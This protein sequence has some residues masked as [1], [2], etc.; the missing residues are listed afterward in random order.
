[1]KRTILILS[2]VLL[3]TQGC[4]EADKSGAERVSVDIKS[5]DNITLKADYYQNAEDDKPLILLF[6]QAGYSRGEYREIGPR[7]NELGFRC[8]AIDQRSGKEVNGVTNEAFAQ[9]NNKGLPTN[10]VDA[11]PDLRAAV[12]YAKKTYEAE[13]IILWGSSYSSSLV[14]ILATEYPG[15]VKGILSFSPGEYFQYNNKPISAYAS[16]VQVP[17]FITSSGAEKELC[18]PIFEAIASDKHYY[19]PDFE[20]YH[21]SKALWQANEGNE[22]YWQEVKSFLAKY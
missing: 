20:G 9:A 14:F 12:E 18:T 4:K 3:L 2:T 5:T 11:L 19:L 22:K 13:N 15:M 7:L 21:G 10:Y 1:M 8:L 17:V 16:Q 6:H